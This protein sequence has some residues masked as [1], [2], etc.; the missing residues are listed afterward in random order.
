MEDDNRTIRDMRR[1]LQLLGAEKE[2]LEGYKERCA[3]LEQEVGELRKQTAELEE[4]MG[5]LCES[6]FIN[7]AYKSE[8]EMME[9]RKHRKFQQVFS[10]SK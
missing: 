7:T 10:F 9:L 3:D 8:R 1:K 5:R 4:S 2:S 6:P